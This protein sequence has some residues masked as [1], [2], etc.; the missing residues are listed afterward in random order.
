M[1]QHKKTDVT[2]H[3]NRIKK[4]K[5][6]QDISV[7]ATKSIGQNPTFHDSILKTGNLEFPLFNI[8]Y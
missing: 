5:A 7:S 6:T 3:I 1:V 4:K 8:L 2:N